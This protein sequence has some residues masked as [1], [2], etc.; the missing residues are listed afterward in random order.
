MHMMNQEYIKLRGKGFKRGSFLSL[1][2]IRASLWLGQDH[3]LCI[4]NKGYEE[5][6]KRFYFRDIQAIITHQDNRRL[7]WNIV[8]GVF[9]LAFTFW[10]LP[11]LTVSAFFLALILINWLRGPTCTCYVQTAVSSENLP[12]LNRLKNVNHAITRLTHVIEQV[13]GQLSQEEIHRHLEAHTQ[14]SSDGELHNTGAI[15]KKR[16]SDAETV[17]SESSNL[18]KGRIHTA[19][20]YALII[21]GIL[22]S[23]DFVHKSVPITTV[24]MIWSSGLSILLIIALVKQQGSGL[25]QWTRRLTWATLGFLCAVSF[26]IYITVIFLTFHSRTAMYTTWDYMR[27]LSSVS[28]YDNSFLMVIYVVSISYCLTA[29]IAGLALMSSDKNK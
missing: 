4:Y 26:I 12:S 6:Y 15:I 8:F 3:M 2:G 16:I 24:Q 7:V 28:P 11:L 14:K 27:M 17:K 18:Y 9:A 22:S 20:F 25:R 23:I 13:Q 29:G 19:M 5:D 21:S 10:G 1:S